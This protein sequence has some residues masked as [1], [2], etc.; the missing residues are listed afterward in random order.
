MKKG[1]YFSEGLFPETGLIYGRLGLG[2][3]TVQAGAS[4]LSADPRRPWPSS[5]LLLGGAKGRPKRETQ[6]SCTVGALR[7]PPQPPKG[8][9]EDQVQ[10]C[11]SLSVHVLSQKHGSCGVGD[12]CCPMPSYKSMCLHVY[13]SVMIPRRLLSHSNPPPFGPYP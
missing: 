10:V 4:T 7:L 2:N 1:G 12:C 11:L 8:A 5:P 13:V 9:K 3:C 6:A